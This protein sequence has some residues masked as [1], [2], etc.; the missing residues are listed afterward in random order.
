[1]G[2]L[3]IH[4]L[5][6]LFFFDKS[7]EFLIIKS[8]SMKKDRYYLSWIFETIS[9]W[10]NDKDIVEYLQVYEDRSLTKDVTRILLR[11]R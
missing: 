3:L 1:M 6:F 2:I 11:V 5:F 9:W 10:S 4:V 8:T 7:R